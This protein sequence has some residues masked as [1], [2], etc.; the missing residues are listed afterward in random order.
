M[1]NDKIAEMKAG[2]E[3]NSIVA[4]EIMGCDVI[5]DEVFGDM[6]RHLD[7]EGNSVYLPLSP[8]SEEMPGAHQVISKMLSLGYDEAEYWKGE[9]RP[10]VIC[11]AALSVIQEKRKEMDKREKKSKLQVVK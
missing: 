1:R 9:T 5:E 4:E 3:L 8:Y 10:E 2:R 11:K 7:K 6:E